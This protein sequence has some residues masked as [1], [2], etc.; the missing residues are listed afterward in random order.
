MNNLGYKIKKNYIVHQ[1]RKSSCNI[2]VYVCVCVRVYVSF[3][4]ADKSFA[5]KILELKVS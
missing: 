2:Y 4:L 3:A 1:Q 5:E